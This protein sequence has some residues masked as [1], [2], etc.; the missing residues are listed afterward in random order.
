MFIQGLV[1]KGLTD[2]QNQGTPFHDGKRKAGTIFQS[3]SGWKIIIKI[4]LMLII[5]P[6]R[7]VIMMKAFQSKSNFLISGTCDI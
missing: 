7:F 6:I 1:V 2:F 3:R 4:R 5:F